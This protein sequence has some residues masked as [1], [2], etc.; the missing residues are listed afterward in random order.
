VKDYREGT[1]LDIATGTRDKAIA[2]PSSN[3]LQFIL[4]AGSI[5]TARPS[6]TEPKIKLYASC[7][8]GPG[9]PLDV[10]RSAVKERITAI[11]EKL[12]ELMA[13]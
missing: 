7:C 13:G 9:E 12:Q 11:E 3:V 6:G 1:I 10:A 5:V 8:S 4:S 2:L